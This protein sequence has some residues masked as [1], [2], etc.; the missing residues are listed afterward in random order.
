MIGFP[1]YL[2]DFLQPLV[3]PLH[4]VV[5]RSRSYD[6]DKVL[7]LKAQERIGLNGL[8]CLCRGASWTRAIL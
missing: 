1:C 2:S 3:P 5:N 6:M 8:D 7:Q 4:M